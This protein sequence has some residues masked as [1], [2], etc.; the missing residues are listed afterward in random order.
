MDDDAVHEDDQKGDR[1]REAV[2]QQVINEE[3]GQ[4]VDQQLRE[5]PPLVEILHP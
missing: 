2:V 1:G 3:P 5:V 4:Q